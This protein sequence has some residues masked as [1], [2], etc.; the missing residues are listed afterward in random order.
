MNKELYKK[1]KITLRKLQNISFKTSTL[2]T[3]LS[4][5]EKTLI[6]KKVK[7]HLIR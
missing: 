4:E 1:I 7:M 3:F 5:N 2:E 6:E